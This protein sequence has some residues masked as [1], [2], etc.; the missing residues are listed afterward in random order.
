[1]ATYPSQNQFIDQQQN[2]SGHLP[3]SKNIGH[4]H[5]VTGGAVPSTSPDNVNKHQQEIDA[6]LLA[7]SESQKS[8]ARRL[9]QFIFNNG[10][11]T[12]KGDGSIQYENRNVPGSNIID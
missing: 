9:L 1:M 10:A 6:L 8:K 2:L 3:L 5:N 12:W 4:L 11:L 7:I